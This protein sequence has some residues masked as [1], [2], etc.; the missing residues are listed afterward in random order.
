MN[1]GEGGCYLLLVAILLL[2][3]LNL[4]G[5]R[6]LAGWVHY[7]RHHWARHGTIAI[8][9]GAHG[10]SL[11]GHTARWR[12]AWSLHKKNVV[13]QDFTVEKENDFLGISFLFHKS[14]HS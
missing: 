9:R 2:D 14:L 11:G 8:S 10:W 1:E 13:S 4:L 7:T 12:H 6:S 5:G 3:L